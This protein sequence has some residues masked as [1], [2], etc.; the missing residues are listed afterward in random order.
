[1]DHKPLT[2][3]VA[4]DVVPAS[5]VANLIET[6]DRDFSQLERDASAARDAALDAE[7]KARQAGVDPKSSAWTMVR[8]QRF[9][10]GLHEEAMRD[11]AATIEVA[12]QRARM[13]LDEARAN[14]RGDSAPRPVLPPPIPPVAPALR[15]VAPVP[16]P[17]PTVMP[18]RPEPFAPARVVTLAPAPV[19]NGHT[20]PAPP[21]GAFAR[22]GPESAP[23]L[24]A[25]VV[26][27]PPVAAPPPA[28]A[29]MAPLAPV[30]PVAPVVAPPPAP[31]AS[32]PVAAAPAPVQPAK[33]RGFFRRLPIAAILEVIAVLLV[34]VFILL[35]LS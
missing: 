7:T 9:L 34:L 16:Q 15:P 10:D 26:A 19:T 8:L 17:E 4:L 22:S 32:A 11:A 27:P 21:E 18:P 31:V 33:K 6:T 3:P 20:Q 5:E 29:P 23:T 2:R 28:P 14:A 12:R 25:P 35:R 1:M 24:L 13:R 30:A